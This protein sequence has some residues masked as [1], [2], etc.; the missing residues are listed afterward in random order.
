M[1]NDQPENR[2]EK[3]KVTSSSRPSVEIRRATSGQR[4][5][6][7]WLMDQDGSR[8]PKERLDKSSRPF[9]PRR[10]AACKQPLLSG[11]SEAKT[12]LGYRGTALEKNRGVRGREPPPF[13]LGLSSETRTLRGED[14]AA[15]EGQPEIHGRARP[16][17]SSQCYLIQDTRCGVPWRI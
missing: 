1:E 16:R 8:A 13:S 12:N 5:L 15:H 17:Q 10:S 7:L 2:P 6:P 11:E 4:F 14:W 3:P 9:H